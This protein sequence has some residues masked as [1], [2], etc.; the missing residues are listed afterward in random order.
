MSDVRFGN[1]RTSE[2]LGS[3]ALSTIYKAV[4]EPL[5]RVVAL[6]TL[7]LQIVETSSFA[8]QLEREAAILADFAHPN[9]VL[10]LELGRADRRPYL[11][12]E[13]VGGPSLKQL[14]GK[15]RK[16][17][18]E[19]ALAIACGVCAGL[20]HV[21]E[22][23]VVHRDVTPSNLLLSKTGIVKI[24]DFGI[25]Q[26]VRTVSVSDAFGAEG[27]TPSGRIIPETN[28]E[29]FGTPAYMSPEQ[30]LGDFVDARSDLFSLGVVL[31]QMLT[32]MRPFEASPHLSPNPPRAGAAKGSLPV[33]RSSR[34]AP[35][36]DTR[37]TGQRIRRDAPPPLRER[38]PDVPRAVERIVMRLLEKSPNDRYPDARTVLERLQTALR[39]MTQEDPSIIL[40]EALIEAGFVRGER[41][42][43][44]D[45]EA[46][47]RA[48]RSIS[49]SRALVGFFVLFVVFALGAFGIQWT[50]PS[51]SA[52]GS[53]AGASILPLVPEDPGG[54]R[55]LAV[56]WA[57]VSVDG[58]HV[59]TTPF[60]RAIPLSAGK[61]FITLTHPDSPDVRR[62][63]DVV[64]GQIVTLEVTMSVPE[65]GGVVAAPNDESDLR[66]AEGRS[67]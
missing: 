33:G 10:L 39:S 61:H 21:H 54:L 43:G 13:Y 55:V 46:R 40:R 31:Y 41:L 44:F 51:A 16:L 66:D 64:A 48:S 20:A 9:V 35:P 37:E 34:P 65:D 67:P 36:L 58:Q 38:A 45:L 47:R 8:E 24:I 5:G 1:Y 23:G 25:A 2:V 15:R 29:T 52:S 57:H 50:S 27:I 14:L 56:P 18:V 19:T 60:A 32:G 3:G 17:P 12:L 49:P 22:H 59:E 62:D 42:Q 30:I 63:V 28:K 4:Q 26:R 7:K 11:V 53:Q 6:K